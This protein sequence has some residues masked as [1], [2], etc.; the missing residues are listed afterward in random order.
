MPDLS[1]YYWTSFGSA[2]IE[3]VEADIRQGGV[4]DER[5]IKAALQ[6]HPGDFRPWEFLPRPVIV[7]GIAEALQPTPDAKVLEIGT[8]TGYLTAVLAALSNRVISL[9]IV[10]TFAA[11]ARRSLEDLP[12]GSKITVI[13]G[14]GSAG[15]P[16][17]APYDCISVH[18]S[19]RQVPSEWKDQLAD[20]GRLLLAIDSENQRE[21]QL[22]TRQ[23]S[24]FSVKALGPGGFSPL[25]GRYGIEKMPGTSRRK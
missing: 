15:Y 16:D 21:L 13:E 20:G 5:I 24:D 11:M 19:V 23:G 25:R 14:D 12:D 9:E 1:Q 6:V 4:T 18:A 2:P 8:G 10:P 7:A 3:D 17:E 22:I